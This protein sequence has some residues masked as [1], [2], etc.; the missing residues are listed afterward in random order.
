MTALAVGFAL[1]LLPAA[2]PPG[3]A[4]PGEVRKRPTENPRLKF[5]L[6][7]QIA[8]AGDGES[9]VTARLLHVW[10][11]KAEAGGKVGDALGFYETYLRH[12]PLDGPLQ[13]Q[14]DLFRD[15][16]IPYDEWHRNSAG[17]ADVWHRAAAR[18]LA[19]L[20]K[21][22]KPT[23]EWFTQSQDALKVYNQ[24]RAAYAKQDHATYMPLADEIIAKYPK[25][26]FVQAAVLTAFTGRCVVSHGRGFENG[27]EVLGGYLKAMDKAGVPRGDRVL[28][29]MAL[30]DQR[31]RRAAPNEKVEPSAELVEA[32]RTARSLPVRQVFLLDQVLDR[33]RA[34]DAAGFRAAAD[35]FVATYP[36]QRAQYAGR[37]RVV[38]AVYGLEYAQVYRPDEL[39]ALIRA[40]RADKAKFYEADAL[41][42]VAGLYEKINK[43]P[44]AVEVCREAVRQASM[45][46]EASRAKFYMA[47]LYQAQGDEKNRLPVLR[48]LADLNADPKAWVPDPFSRHA[49]R[50]LLADHHFARK[51]WK[52]ALA[53][54]EVWD[55]HSGCGLGAIEGKK[56]KESRIAECRKNLG[57]P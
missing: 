11:E 57:K 44:A 23:A 4:K 48:D 38:D 26:I 43:L 29:L 52:E 18:Y 34:K 14:L 2:D 51:E 46:G 36:T 33:V 1:V 17:D 56:K 47:R 42:L 49:A 10:A 30:H 12:F 13:W 32:R 54:Y 20:A 50:E 27:V 16:A 9:A 24:L 6:D 31:L 5:L 8:E 25:S 45:P 53:I 40:W 21:T 19:L 15:V 7:D 41:Q 37:K 55:S 35:A 3:E 39:L 28:V 22:E